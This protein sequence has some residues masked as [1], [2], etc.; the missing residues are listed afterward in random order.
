M[1]QTLSSSPSQRVPVVPSQ[2]RLPPTVMGRSHSGT[3]SA[4]GT[5]SKA[6]SQSFAQYANGHATEMQQRR[7]DSDRD[8]MDVDDG[9]AIVPSQRR[10]YGFDGFEGGEGAEVRIRVS[11]PPSCCLTD[12]FLYA[13]LAF[14]VISNGFP[15][16][17]TNSLP[18]L[19]SR[20]NRK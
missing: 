4:P 11:F 5:L 13:C 16:P 6:N 17:H 3:M 2:A 10:Q 12:L 15:A 1:S 20:C 18:I 7:G 9:R 14:V 8:E 19:L